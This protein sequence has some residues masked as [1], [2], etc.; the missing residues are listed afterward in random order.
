MTIASHLL[1]AQTI[2]WTVKGLFTFMLI[3][4]FLK[5][6]RE[7]QPV[8]NPSLRINYL[9]RIRSS[10]GKKKE[11]QRLMVAVKTTE[12]AGKMEFTKTVFEHK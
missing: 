3:I 7:S 6:S 10:S 9:F 4:C 11:S 2:K 5:V 1:P 8:P 12:E